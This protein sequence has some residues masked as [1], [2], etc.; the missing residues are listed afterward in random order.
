[1]DSKEHAV[2]KVEIGHGE[3]WGPFEVSFRV[4]NVG[5]GRGRKSVA[6]MARPICMLRVAGKVA[7]V[8]N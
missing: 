4:E 7:G 2:T 6:E 5:G 8:L 1:M 3:D